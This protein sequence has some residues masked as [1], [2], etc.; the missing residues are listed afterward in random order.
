MKPVL[1]V[2]C[3]TLGIGLMIFSGYLPKSASADDNGPDMHVPADA[4]HTYQSLYQDRPRLP[5]ARVRPAS[6]PDGPYADNAYVDGGYLDAYPDVPAD[7]P[8]PDGPLTDRLPDD[9]AEEAAQTL[10]SVAA[11]LADSESS[12]ASDGMDADSAELPPPPV[13][14]AGRDRVV[15]I[16]WDEIVLDGSA[17]TGE[18]LSYDWL[19]IAGARTLEI[20]NARRARAAA[21][22]AFDDVPGWPQAAYEFELLVTDK[23][24]RESFD[25]VEIVV[26]SAPALT[27]S[28]S[29]RR[30]FEY[31][32]GYLLG[33]YE[34]W[35]TNLET[36][37]F[38]FQIVAHQELTF[39]RVSG[40]EYDLSGGPLEGLYVYR[41]TLYAQ[42]DEPTSWAEFLVDTAEQVPGVVQ[43]GVSWV[44]R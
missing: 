22:L 19:Q 16:G 28:P 33:H 11:A 5:A 23:H 12:P 42:R 18:E 35:A 17:S 25:S 43:L 40:G 32:D 30:R 3:F 39:T 31:R 37:D 34:A 15:W 38:T 1:F 2:V 36:F 4:P 29:A 20:A 24:G 26:K 13:A 8:E 21:E 7:E 44:G 27:I 14:D 41:I 6:D 10:A 9:A